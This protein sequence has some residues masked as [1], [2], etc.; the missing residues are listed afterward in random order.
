LQESSA[1]TTHILP[2]APALLRQV[3]IRL[4]RPPDPIEN[5]QFSQTCPLLSRLKAA[6]CSSV[7]IISFSKFSIL[8][9]QFY[10]LKTS[11]KKTLPP[12]PL[13]KLARLVRKSSIFLLTKIAKSLRT[14][15]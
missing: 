11:Q 4:P 6:V 15:A 13:H 3:K 9:S 8:H 1:S 12:H 10:I 2:G 5:R 7:L 14:T